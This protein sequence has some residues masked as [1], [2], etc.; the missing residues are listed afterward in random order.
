[1]VRERSFSEYCCKGLP[2]NC[3]T[4]THNYGKQGSCGCGGGYGNYCII[5]HGGG[6]STV[7]AHATEIIVKEGQQVST[8]D[9]IG[10]V[11]STG[12]STGYHLHFEVRIDGERKNPESFNLLKY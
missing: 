1:M 10:Y 2:S 8:G 3:N 5:D 11:G 6:Y 12:E 9:V 4:C 7:Y